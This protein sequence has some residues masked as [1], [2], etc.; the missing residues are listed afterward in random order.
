MREEYRAM[1]LSCCFG[2]MAWW[3]GDDACVIIEVPEFGGLRHVP[4]KN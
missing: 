1:L 3:A 2:S 4:P